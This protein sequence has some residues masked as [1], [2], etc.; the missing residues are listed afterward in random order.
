MRIIEER[1]GDPSD[2]IPIWPRPIFRE[3]TEEEERPDP[4]TFPRRVHPRF[5]TVSQ[6]FEKRHQGRS[7]AFRNRKRQVNRGEFK[8]VLRDSPIAEQM[9]WE[10]VEK[11]SPLWLERQAKHWKIEIERMFTPWPVNADVSLEQMDERRERML[12][13][14]EIP[15]L[16]YPRRRESAVQIMDLPDNHEA[17]QEMVAKN[18]LFKEQ[19]WRNL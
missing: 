17:V 12:G 11:G 5:D 10:S 15:F 18:P 14:L 13:H 16:R 6:G 19:K 7:Q 1:G 2:L 9:L 8:E 4:R 3:H